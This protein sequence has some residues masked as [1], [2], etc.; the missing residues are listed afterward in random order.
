[1]FASARCSFDNE[2]VPGVEGCEFANDQTNFVSLAH[3]ELTSFLQRTVA[4]TAFTQNA[5]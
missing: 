5:V 4:I 2:L 1:V 3:R